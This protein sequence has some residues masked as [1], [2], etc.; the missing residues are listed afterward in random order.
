MK[1]TVLVVDDDDILRTGIAH[2]LRSAGFDVITAPNAEFADEILNRVTPDAI[3]LD[4]MMTGMDGLGFLK[5]IRASGNKTPTIMLTA[6][7][8]A[9][10]AIDGLMGGADD[11]LSKPFQMR[12]LILRINNIISRNI[13]PESKMPNGLYVSNDEFFVMGTDGTPYAIMLSNEEKKLLHNMLNP[14][15]CIIPAQPMVAKRLREKL[16]N[17]L[18]NIDIITVRG[19]GYKIVC[20]D[21]VR[22]QNQK[23]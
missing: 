12:E 21:S 20:R 23:E 13:A 3:V 17:V 8:G 16:N 4:R 6:M 11:Y 1:K 7:G 5:K 18:S 14:L 19:R 9:E 22:K 2:G 15:G 10:N